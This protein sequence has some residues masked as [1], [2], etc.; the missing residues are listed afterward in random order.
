MIKDS[1]LK[2]PRLS[3]RPF[4]LEKKIPAGKV[5]FK[6]IAKKI[7]IPNGSLTLGSFSETNTITLKTELYKKEIF[8]ME[9]ILTRV[10]LYDQLISKYEYKDKQIFT[11]ATFRT[12]FFI[13][14]QINDA[15]LYVLSSKDTISQIKNALS[16]LFIEVFD[17]EIYSYRLSKTKTKILREKLEIRLKRITADLDQPG[18]D[19][20]SI[21]GDDPDKRPF[22]KQLPGKKE[23]VKFQGYVRPINISETWYIIIAEDGGIYS[24]NSISCKDIIDFHMLE[25]LPHL[26]IKKKSI[27]TREDLVKLKEFRQSSM[28]EF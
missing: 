2:I 13:K 14:N 24:T 27:L 21:K 1:Y 3:I 9:N 12:Q 7:P 19:Q 10:I 22:Y 5:S 20:I 25:V 18:I 15:I 26:S 17:T 23:L 16:K 11:P 6:S 4:H 28:A 8:A